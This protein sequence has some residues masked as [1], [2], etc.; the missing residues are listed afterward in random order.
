MCFSDQL[1]LE[2]SKVLNDVVIW[3][4]EIQVLH[5]LCYEEVLLVL[6]DFLL[7]FDVF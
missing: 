7:P 1:F 5:L 3:L 6:V 4:L 2:L